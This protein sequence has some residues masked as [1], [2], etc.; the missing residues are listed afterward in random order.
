MLRKPK[1][2]TPSSS[3]SHRRNPTRLELRVS[4]ID[5]PRSI[6]D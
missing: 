3:D 2:L 4:E 5:D 1:A 6:F